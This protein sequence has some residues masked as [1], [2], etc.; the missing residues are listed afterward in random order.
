M[1]IVVDSNILFTFFW[2]ESVFEDILNTK[3]LDLFASE[4]ALDEIKKYKEEIIKKGNISEKEF[5]QKKEELKRKVKF[6][7]FKEYD[8]EIK[9][10][11]EVYNKENKEIIE[12]LLRDIDFLALALRLNTVLWS[13][14]KLLKSQKVITILKTEEIIRLL[15]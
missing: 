3:R 14:D 7:H 9:E 13:N 15:S 8:T 6:F 11:V 2:K 12:E 10:I 4:I 1:K 5:E